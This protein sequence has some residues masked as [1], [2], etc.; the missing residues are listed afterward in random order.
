MGRKTVEGV[1]QAQRPAARV[2]GE[3]PHLA[4]LEVGLRGE[5]AHDVEVAA[6]RAHPD[7]AQTTRPWLITLA[8]FAQVLGPEHP[9]TLGGQMNL[10]L[11]LINQGKG[12]AAVREQCATKRRNSAPAEQR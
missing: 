2:A 1:D 10:A 11:A 4:Q 12:A 5:P 8:G 7:E 6:A 3:H 9:D